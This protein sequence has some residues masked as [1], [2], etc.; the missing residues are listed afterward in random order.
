[1]A[2]AGPIMY[3]GHSEVLDVDAASP[4]TRYQAYGDGKDDRDRRGSLQ[5]DA[6]YSVM[7]RGVATERRCNDCCCAA[8]FLLVLAGAI[9]S[10]SVALENANFNITAAR[11]AALAPGGACEGASAAALPPG[12]ADFDSFLE[13]VAASGGA[14]LAAM[15][16]AGVFVGIVWVQLLRCF[17]RALVYITLFFIPAALLF[18]GVAVQL[19]VIALGLDDTATR[20]TMGGLF[21]L[22]LIYLLV[23]C[24]LRRRIPQTIFLL[25]NAGRALSENLG[26]FVISAA[27]F[28]LYVIVMAALATG[29]IA[30]LFNGAFELD[31]EVEAGEEA[32]CVWELDEIGGTALAGCS[33]LLLWTSL[34][35]VELRAAAVAGAVGLWY[36]HSADAE[37][38]RWPATTSMVWAF[39]KSF[40]AQQSQP[41]S[42]AQKT[43]AVRRLSNSRLGWAAGSLCA[44]SLI[45]V[46]IQLLRIVVNAMRRSAHESNATALRKL[47]LCICATLCD[48][49]YKWVKFFTSFVT[50]AVALGGRSFW[51]SAKGV[52]DLFTRRTPQT[53][54]RLTRL[55]GTTYLVLS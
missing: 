39:T 29:L 22:T 41:D 6:F 48:C 28:L 26:V 25:Q 47:L 49:M 13:E 24:C 7:Q 50:I 46:L 12:V 8:L 2:D 5:G 35:F 53:P 3:G 18:F 19:N 21:G 1:M 14:A 42:L 36:H 9:S 33:F 32:A 37:P 30:A 4:T 54:L 31:D 10:G 43:P 38:P 23:L 20:S 17:A 44:G 55:I 40:G 52:A 15:V 45:L 16:G 51:Q 27:I 11:A 34:L